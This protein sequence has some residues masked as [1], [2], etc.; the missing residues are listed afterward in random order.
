MPRPHVTLSEQLRLFEAVLSS[1]ATAQ[2]QQ[3]VE[4]LLREDQQA[5]ERYVEFTHQDVELRHA[6]RIRLIDPGISVEADCAC[7]LPPEGISP[8]RASCSTVPQAVVRRS[9]RWFAHWRRSA[10]VVAAAATTLAASVGIYLQMRPS[11]EAVASPTNPNLLVAPVVFATV[12]PAPVATLSMHKEAEWRDQELK[13]GQ[14]LS[15]GDRIDLISGEAHISMGAGAEISI[16]APCALTFVAADRIQLEVGE[17]VIHVAEWAKGFTVETPAMEVVDLGTTFTVSASPDAS[18]ETNVLQGQ[19]RVSPRHHTADGRRSVLVSEGKGFRIDGSGECVARE[20]AA[21]ELVA[22]GEW[23][24]YAPY[25]PVV[26]HNTG[27]DINVGDEDPHWRVV[28][29]PEDSFSGPQFAMV[30]I[31]DERYLPNDRETSQ[32]VSMANW[33]NASPN[34]IFTFQTTFDLTGFDLHTIQLFGRFLADNGVS[35]VRVNGVAVELESWSDNASGQKF[36]HPQFRTVNVTKGLING[37]NIIE[38]DVWNGTFVQTPPIPTP[39][40]MALRVEWQAF[41]RMAPN[42]IRLTGVLSLVTSRPH[43]VQSLIH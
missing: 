17:A 40:P 28:A 8:P 1:T 24:M 37:T 30:C 23:G 9:G 6:F 11:A 22:W 10:L 5:L 4:T 34:A 13:D 2:E 36:E 29:G 39:N 19:V 31:P 7:G 12:P 20:L 3:M 43:W 25:R 42:E 16:K 18:A 26:L 21:P 35:E 33:R 15:E 38:V 27:H 14:S 32:W 41:G